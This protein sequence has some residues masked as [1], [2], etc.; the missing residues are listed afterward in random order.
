MDQH[1]QGPCGEVCDVCN[2]KDDC[3]I[4]PMQWRDWLS[5]D[6]RDPASKD[7]ACTDAR[8]VPYMR[9]ENED[10]EL[11]GWID[12]LLV[13]CWNEFKR[14][15]FIYRYPLSREKLRPYLKDILKN[16]LSHRE[17][18]V[19]TMHLGLDSGET[20]SFG[21]MSDYFNISGDSLGIIY[22]G[23]IEKLQKAIVKDRRWRRRGPDG[24]FTA[25]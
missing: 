5:V 8:K 13:D 25:I 7:D 21:K 1:N 6:L 18:Q 24:R 11:M 19:I 17:R 22:R 12:K 15:D 9:Y 23:A 20:L 14:D 2:I 10:G 3:P 16:N 4:T